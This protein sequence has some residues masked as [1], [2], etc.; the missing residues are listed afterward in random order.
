MLS[1][2]FT[3]GSADHVHGEM[4]AE[5]VQQ[6]EEALLEFSTTPKFTCCELR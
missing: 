3:L 2:G 1:L 4:G 6:A 5:R